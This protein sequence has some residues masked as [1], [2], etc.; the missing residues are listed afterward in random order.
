M[1]KS[2]LNKT[3]NEHNETAAKILKRYNANVRFDSKYIITHSKV[4]IVDDSV[5]VG[6][7]N[8]DDSSL[9]TNHE[10]GVVLNDSEVA[11]KFWKYFEALWVMSDY[12]DK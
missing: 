6:S 10:T 11:G 4:V 5:I 2:D 12:G 1:E 7:Y 9:E 3:I 8:W